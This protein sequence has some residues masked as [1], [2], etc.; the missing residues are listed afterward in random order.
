MIPSRVW[1]ATHGVAG[2]RALA[3]AARAGPSGGRALLP[4]VLLG[5]TT[6]AAYTGYQLTAHPALAEKKANAGVA[7]TDKERTY[8][9]IKPDGVQRGLIGEIINRFERKGFKLV[10]LKMVTPSKEL[11]AQH[12]DDL[13]SKPFFKGLV[14]YMSS[15][16]PVICMVWEGKGVIKTARKML[17][18]TNPADSD[19]GTIRGDYCVVVGRNAIHGS[20]SFESA[21]AEIALWFSDKEINE[22]EPT[23]A[24]WITSDN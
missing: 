13:K 21:N 20:D 10:A 9:M 11:A 15:G 1:Y 14:D 18:A 24:Q 23:L 5:A 4:T 16:T 22:W 3:T 6:L 8:I 7:G 12:Y 19:V 2:S 17:G